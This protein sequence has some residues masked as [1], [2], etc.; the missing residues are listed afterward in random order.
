MC[1]PIIFFRQCLVD[2]VVEVFV[3]GEYNMPTDIVKLAGVSAY[4]Y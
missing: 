4:S 3:M 2:T 1:V